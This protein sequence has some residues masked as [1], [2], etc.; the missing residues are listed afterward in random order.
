MRSREKLSMEPPRR[1]LVNVMT[2][3]EQAER[4][5]ADEVK[6]LKQAPRCPRFLIVG[7]RLPEG[8]TCLISSCPREFQ[9]IS[10]P[11]LRS[12]LQKLETTWAA[13]HR[14]SA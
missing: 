13:E 10:E 3:S 4:R 2:K 11:E 6:L 9:K 1:G 8:F 12:R 7:P 5:F 14:I